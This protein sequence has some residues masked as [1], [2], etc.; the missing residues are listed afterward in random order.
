VATAWIGLGSNLG[1]RDAS[2]RAALDALA[3]TPGVRVRRVSAFRETEPVGGP[4]QGAFLNAAAE[5]ETD[6]PPRALLDR[7]LAIESSLGRRR[8]VRWGPRL[9]DLDLLLYDDLVVDEPGLRVPHPLMH[10][11]RFVL[12]PLAEINPGLRHPLLGKTVLELL[13]ELG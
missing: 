9:I 7:L 8:E 4:P 11:R 1:D 5:I 12:G 6:L 10:E 3:A 13:A 2:L